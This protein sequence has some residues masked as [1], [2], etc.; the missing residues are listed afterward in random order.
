MGYE[1]TFDYS[2]SEKC[3][4]GNIK[5]LNEEIAKL[6]GGMGEVKFFKSVYDI[7]DE[8][9]EDYWIEMDD[10]YGKFYDDKE[11]AELLSKYIVKGY[12]DLIYTGEDGARSG[13]RAY[14]NRVKSLKFTVKV[15]D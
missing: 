15:I 4:I 5:E 13:F 11:F 10:S 12:V 6:K 3:R 2:F 1:S 8:I 14:S 9:V 7:A